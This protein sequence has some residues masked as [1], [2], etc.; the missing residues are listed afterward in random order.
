M[1]TY[2]DTKNHQDYFKLFAKAQEILAA[3]ADAGKL[4]E[5]ITRD[6][7]DIGTLNQ[8]F[9]YLE[10]LIDPEINAN[11]NLRSYFMRLPLDEDFLEIDTN[12]RAVKVPTIFSRNGVGVQGDESAEIVYFKVN[13]YFDNIDLANNDVKIVIQ[14]EAKDKDKKTITGISPNFGKDIE[15]VPGSIIFGWPIYGEFTE[16]AGTIKFAVRFYMVGAEDESTHTRALTYSLAT[17][18]A[19]LSINAT[20]AYDLLDAS[21]R[22]VEH[23]KMI[24]NR[25]KNVGIYDPSIPVPG[26]PVI[27]TPLGLVEIIREQNGD[28]HVV[29]VS[30]SHIADLPEEGEGVT[31]GVVARPSDFG[32]IQYIWRKWPYIKE[33]GEYET[34]KGKT[35]ILTEGIDNGV[36]EE[37]TEDLGDDI[38]YRETSVNGATVKTYAPIVVDSE[39]R[40]P[41]YIEDQGFQSTDGSYI[42]LYKKYSTATVDATGIY[43]VDIG[44]R[45]G[46]NSVITEMEPAD[47]IKIPGPL[48]PTVTPV[49]EE[50]N[51]NVIVTEDG[52]TH[53]IV[54]DGLA[55]LKVAGAR[56]ETDADAKVDLTFNWVQN[57]EGQQVPLA[58]DTVAPAQVKAYL[59]GIDGHG[60][61]PNNAA[62]AAVRDDAAYNQEHVS[63][64]Q[65]GSEVTIYATEELRTFAST[66]ANQGSGEWLGI[67][68][69]T[70][71]EDITELTWNGYSL[72]SDDVADAESVGLGAG[73]IIFW[74]KAA[75]LASSARHIVLG[76][77]LELTISLVRELP[78]S[79]EYTFNEDKTQMNITGLVETNLDKLYCVNVTA[80]RNGVETTKTSGNY[81]LT[82]APEKPVL[83]RNV[84]NQAAGKYDIIVSDYTTEA[85]ALT[86]YTKNRNEEYNKVAF[87]VSPIAKTDGLKYIWMRARIEDTVDSDWI[88]A[89]IPKLQ[90]DIGD[91][92]GT[93]FAD[94]IG[95]SDIP[96]EQ[97]A[98][99]MKTLSNLGEIIE[100]EDN[101][102]SLQIDANTE[103]GYY[104]CIV[105]NELNSHRVAN[106][107]PFYHI[108]IRNR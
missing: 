108:T 106:V 54:R 46:T 43:T 94:P 86:V 1:V 26:N 107:S 55:S 4:P 38:Y 29:S 30:S 25:I 36:Y 6:Q 75:D 60:H 56:G 92:L 76:D 74:A 103:L 105:V 71:T 81:R 18:P 37:V 70:G 12:T 34:N 50:N 66:D 48:K 47:G 95:D 67:D 62:Y 19:E 96:V 2:I 99:L 63:L 69:D 53:I 90:V 44:A 68:I 10:N 3:A 72:S 52:V 59:L 89:E 82:N 45:Y 31:L 23:G 84:W 14:W 87:S 61:L 51:P 39:L 101:G 65:S 80:T 88:T 24:T 16:T 93:L 27:S 9:A 98:F 5:G 78:A 100:G 22:E 85:E 8:Y 7:L 64:A 79:A 91:A 41:V 57:I 40:S 21:V 28:V 102:P 15:S 17:L 58:G 73:H 20:L 104:Y 77:D 33:T 83:K 97:D 35:V 49:V 11:E 13:R 42:K 32:A